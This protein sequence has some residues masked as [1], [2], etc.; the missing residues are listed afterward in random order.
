MAQ[1]E[2]IRVEVVALEGFVEAAARKVGIPEE[3]ARLLGRL[4]V[5]CDLWGVRS[6]GS[7]QIA[8]YVREI[9]SGGINPRPTI[10][11]VQETA[12]SLVMEGDGGL[13]YFPMY[14]GMEAAIEK[15]KQQGMAALVTRHHGHIGAAGIYSRMPLKEDMVAFVTSGVQMHLGP[16]RRV[17]DATG[18]PPMSFSAP[19]GEEA[20]MVL[21]AAVTHGLFR[22]EVRQELGRIAPAMALRTFGLGVVCQVW[23]GLLAGVPV[24]PGRAHRTFAAATQGAMAVVVQVGLFADPGRFKAEMDEFVRRARRM[25]PMEGTKGAYLPGGVEV[26]RT[27]RYRAAGVPLGPRHRANLEEVAKALGIKAP[28]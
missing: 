2:R 7:G 3:Q 18:S 12:V 20:P 14:Q 9:R 16:Q 27:R 26:E 1:D 8:R 13:G 25:K 6:H 24:D 22:K 15:A 11:K 23:G 5:D 28:W 21:D 17:H 10:R 4:L 19:A